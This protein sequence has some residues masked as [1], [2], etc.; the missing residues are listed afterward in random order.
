MRRIAALLVVFGICI[1]ASAQAALTIEQANQLSYLLTLAG[2][3]APASTSVPS[4]SSTQPVSSLILGALQ[5]A[6]PGSFNFA[7]LYATPSTST[8]TSTA[9]ASST[10]SVVEALEI[11]II[12]L[13]GQLAA[14]IRDKALGIQKTP[15]PDV[16]EASVVS[17][18]AAPADPEDTVP[19][20][21]ECPVITRTL[22]KNMEGDDV[23]ALQEYL[24]RIHLM[25]VGGASGYF[26]ALTEGALKVWQR[27]QG[28]DPLGITGPKTR[29][30][31]LDC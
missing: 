22:M 11:K 18:P 19:S 28:L 13:K 30:L 26:G 4:A 29:E 15:Q 5:N 12:Q 8:A 14:L 25:D 27:A 20:D 16:A 21:A 10:M 23:R 1:P 3:G 17:E 7:D 24:I 6:A 2:T 9:T 31:L